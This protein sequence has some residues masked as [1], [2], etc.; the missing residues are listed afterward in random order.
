[1][2]EPAELPGV[3]RRFLRYVQIDTQSDRH[4]ATTPSTEKQKDLGRLLVRELQ[5]LGIDGA[6]IDEHGYVY[7]SLA[8]TL[9]PY[10]PNRPRSSGTSRLMGG[11]RVIGSSRKPWRFG[12]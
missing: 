11:V 7:A 1:M 4:S 3:A 6:E 5:A 9:P 12:I 10:L 8:S 2:A